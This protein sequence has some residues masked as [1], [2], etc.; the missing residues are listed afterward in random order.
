[1]NSFYQFY[2]RNNGNLSQQ[3]FNHFWTGRY[4]KAIGIYKPFIKTLG[5]IESLGM[6]DALVYLH[7]LLMSG[8]GQEE[9]LNFPDPPSRSEILALF[10]YESSEEKKNFIAADTEK[11]LLSQPEIL[12]KSI[13]VSKIGVENNCKIAIETG[14]FLGASTYLFSGVFD[15]VHTIE[16]DENLYK[17][18]NYWLKSLRNN[19]ETYHGDS[20]EILNVILQKVDEPCIIFLDAH[21]SEGVTS[22]KYGIT[23]LLEELKYIL[24]STHRHIV[25]I[26]DIR[27][28]ETPGYPS[29][30][31]IINII[32]RGRK[33]LIEQDQLILT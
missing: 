3:A 2:T 14:T 13:L 17:T 22:K 16:A 6:L 21:W 12:N 1:M 7:C 19:I 31:E 25:V 27:C 23:P 10:S 8:K 29:F 28:L 4:K 20:G 9:K 33:L 24:N 5:T 32:P 11:N 15:K 26:D 30:K 18:S